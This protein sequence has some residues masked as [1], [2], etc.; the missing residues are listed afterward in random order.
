MAAVSSAILRPLG[1]DGVAL[2][3]P[4]TGDITGFWTLPAHARLNWRESDGEFVVYNGLD[5]AVHFLDD[6]NAV[7]FSVLIEADQPLATD[8]LAQLM[9]AQCT[10]DTT[11][12]DAVAALVKILP[13][14]RRLGLVEHRLDFK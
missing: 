13:E 3:E 10:V 1:P 9:L 8:Q 6:V 7:L 14:F 5:D 4:D 2:H 11:A 12:G